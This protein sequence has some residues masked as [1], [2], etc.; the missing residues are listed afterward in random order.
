MWTELFENFGSD[1][2]I[3]AIDLKKQFYFK[4]AAYRNLPQLPESQW[5]DYKVDNTKRLELDIAIA[6]GMLLDDDYERELGLVYA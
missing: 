2:W 3:L 5:N 4:G 1:P 6:Y